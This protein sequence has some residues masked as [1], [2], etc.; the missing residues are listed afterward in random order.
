M[1]SPAN[2]FAPWTALSKVFIKKQYHAGYVEEVGQYVVFLFEQRDQHGRIL[3]DSFSIGEIRP[4]VD[5]SR[6]F[7][8]D[9]A[10]S[11][12]TLAGFVLPA[13][14][15]SYD[16]YYR[17]SRQRWA[18]PPPIS[19]DTPSAF[20]R[21]APSPDKDKELRDLKDLHDRGLVTDEVYKSRQLEIL[22][23]K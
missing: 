11:L 23:R 1:S 5:R 9:V 19:S 15:A 10:L 8:Y 13:S 7:A 22:N 17:D 12:K 2:R 4:D 21:T 18:T 14:Y 20:D 16:Y 3:E 6:D